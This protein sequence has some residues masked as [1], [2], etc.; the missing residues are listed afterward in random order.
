M[1]TNVANRR[2][3]TNRGKRKWSGDEP[4]PET[5]VDDTAARLKRATAIH[6]KGGPLFALPDMYQSARSPGAHVF[7]CPVPRLED[8]ACFAAMVS[9]VSA[10]PVAYVGPSIADDLAKFGLRLGDT[11][12]RSVMHVPAE[13]VDEAVA[14]WT[15]SDISGVVLLISNGCPP[16]LGLSSLS[17]TAS[18]TVR[19]VVTF[20]DARSEHVAAA[21][22]RRIDIGTVYSPPTYWNF[23]LMNIANRG[24]RE[25]VTA[26]LKETWSAAGRAAWVAAADS[27]V[28]SDAQCTVCMEPCTQ[29]SVGACCTGTYCFDCLRP[30]VERHYNCPSCRADAD[31]TTFHVVDD[32]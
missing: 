18:R 31:Y 6:G 17:S 10:R 16:G 1:F 27:R 21:R 5:V 8:V 12:R 9:S 2:A 24:S 3:A 28:A 13:G 15:S 30:W 25:Q 14:A 32:H 4:G 22:E 19:A 11:F 26:S 7:V 29:A 20:A 23:C